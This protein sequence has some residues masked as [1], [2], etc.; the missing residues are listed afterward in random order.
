MIHTRL[1]VVV[2]CLF[3]ASSC[4]A[5]SV[6]SD[7]GPTGSTVATPDTSPNP[8]TSARLDSLSEVPPLLGAQ[9]D[10]Q[11]AVWA[12]SVLEAP[13]VA[14]CLAEKGF[15]YGTNL[16]DRPPVRSVTDMIAER[17]GEPRKLPDGQYAYYVPT[18]DVDSS[19]LEESSRSPDESAALVGSVIESRNILDEE[20]QVVATLTVGDGCLGEAQAWLFGSPKAYLDYW[21]TL[22]SI[23]VK[24]SS[25]LVRLLSDPTFIAANASWSACMHNAGF[26]F[27][28]VIDPS[29][30]DWDYPR[31]GPREKAAAQ[32]DLTCRAT[33]GLSVEM[34][35]QIEMRLEELTA[36]DLP[37][38]FKEYEE[39]QR[40]L[41]ER[42]SRG[43]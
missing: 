9:L 5:S 19:D 28:T 6:S 16:P 26:E 22:N 10:I 32:A 21:T 13:K 43:S 30:S 36:P 29:N 8:S 38:T 40:N 42:A 2:A 20:G 35:A 4:S 25:I 39:V 23:T 14:A 3:I 11:Q 27:K 24:S 7:A 15:T 18:K 33:S 37:L 17:F 31:P 41:I 12:I 1:G 34:L